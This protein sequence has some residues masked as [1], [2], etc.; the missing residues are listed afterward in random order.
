MFP[1]FCCELE[2]GLPPGKVQLY[3]AIGP[4]GSLPVPVKD[5]AWPGFTV[6]FVSGLAIETLGGR[7]LAD[8]TSRTNVATD[9]TPAEFSTNSM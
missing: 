6:T 5:T 1:G 7:L 8:A 2:L 3:E 4:S 9:G